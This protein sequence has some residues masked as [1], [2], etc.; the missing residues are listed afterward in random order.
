MIKVVL[1]PPLKCRASDWDNLIVEPWFD[2]F[3]TLNGEC[4]PDPSMR[5]VHLGM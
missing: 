3:A 2:L 4:R 5:P 1:H